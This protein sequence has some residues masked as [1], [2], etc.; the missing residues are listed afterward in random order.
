MNLAKAKGEG[1]RPTR[2]DV[3][4]YAFECRLAVSFEIAPGQSFLLTAV[5]R[6]SLGT[7]QID[8]RSSIAMSSG[9][10]PPDKPPPP[11]AAA[12]SAAAVTPSSQKSKKAR[13]S[14]SGSIAS[15]FEEQLTTEEVKCAFVITHARGHEPRGIQWLQTEEKKALDRVRKALDEKKF[16]VAREQKSQLDGHRLNIGMEEKL[17][18]YCRDL[19]KRVDGR[20]EHFSKKLDIDKIQAWNAVKEVCEAYLEKVPACD[21]SGASG[22]PTNMHHTCYCFSVC[23]CLHFCSLVFLF[24]DPNV[25]ATS[26]SSNSSP[27]SS[28]T[29]TADE[30]TT[31]VAAAAAS[32]TAT[33]AATDPEAAGTDAGNTSTEDEDG[34]TTGTKE[35]SASRKRKGMAFSSKSTVDCKPKK[36]VQKPTPIQYDRFKSLT[37]YKKKDM[38]VDPSA[39]PY[40]LLNGFLFCCDKKGGCGTVIDWNNRAKHLTTAKH[41]GNV[42]SHAERKENAAEGRRIVQERI[43]RESLVGSTYTDEEIERSMTYARM[44]FAGNMAFE[45]A[46]AIKVSIDAM[47]ACPIVYFSSHPYL[48]NILGHVHMRFLHDTCSLSWKS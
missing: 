42:K 43:E 14:K 30:S 23:M 19:S 4:T 3:A 11:K 13:T 22:E 25:S 27:T 35:H 39:S 46:N 15:F 8:S 21:L 37:S 2:S 16:D 5:H 31:S 41:I 7:I 44:F 10:P 45:N 48:T 18:A 36:N 9:K 38:V 24:P 17:L 40:C 12:A 26:G 29:E 20:I 33:N 47:C 1:E 28:A 6:T 34:E 32:G